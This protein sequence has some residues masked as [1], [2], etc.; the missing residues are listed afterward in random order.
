MQALAAEG[1]GGRTDTAA[2]GHAAVPA[3]SQQSL[4]NGL[5]DP[6][7]VPATSNGSEQHTA[8]DGRRSDGPVAA[9]QVA[10]AGRRAGRI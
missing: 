9:L 8:M 6:W 10:D 7:A 5:E 2:N 3:D 4:A 1:G